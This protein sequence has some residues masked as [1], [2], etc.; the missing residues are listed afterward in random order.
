MKNYTQVYV[1]I[2]LKQQKH[3]VK[4]LVQRLPVNL[5]TRTTLHMNTVS[6]L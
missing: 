1:K 6:Y 2:V 5:K 4:L 3:I